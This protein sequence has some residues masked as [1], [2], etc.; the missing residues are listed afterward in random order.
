MPI[1]RTFAPVVAGV[2]KMDYRRFLFYNIFGGVG[3]V[4]SMIMI[5][6]FLTSVIDPP[7]KAMFGEEFRVQNHIEKVII[8]VVFLSIGPV[9]SL[10]EKEADQKG[11]GRKQPAARGSAGTWGLR[12]SSSF[13]VSRSCTC[14]TIKQDLIACLA[15]AAAPFPARVGGGKGRLLRWR[16]RRRRQRASTLEPLPS[17][18]G[19]GAKG[20]RRRLLAGRL[21]TLG[22]ASAVGMA[23]GSL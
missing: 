11:H 4:V 16:R 7:F 3:W 15:A 23:S 12:R 6:Y 22:A 9:F 17:D 2:G 19:G 18:G 10:A 8:I 1:I 14:A 21:S 13:I 5:G 20:R